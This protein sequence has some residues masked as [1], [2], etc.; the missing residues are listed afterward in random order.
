MKKQ[1]IVDKR[2]GARCQYAIVHDEDEQGLR[3]QE[4]NC[5]PSSDHKNHESRKRSERNT[6]EAVRNGGDK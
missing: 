6:S 1:S 5:A 3:S 4:R 2:S